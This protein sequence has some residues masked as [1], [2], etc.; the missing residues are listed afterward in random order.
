M[1]S[2]INYL[3]NFGSLLG[4]CL[5]RQIVSG[6]F[7]TMYFCSNSEYAFNSLIQIMNN[8]NSGWII[9]YRHSSRASIFFI[10]C[11]IHVGKGLIYDSFYFWKIWF[12]GLIL[13]FILIAIAF[14][15][16]VLPWGQMSFWGATVITNLI[17]VIPLVGPIVVEWLWGGFNVAR[18]TLSRFFSFHFIL[19]LLIVILVLTHLIVLH[20]KGSSNPLGMPLNL[21]KIRFK[22][23]F[24]IKDIITLIVYFFF[25]L[26]LNFRFPFIFRDPENF[27][28]A[29]PILTPIHIQPEWYFLFAYCILRAVPS[30]IGGVILLVLS[31]LI[32]I[33]LSL[34]K[35]KK[36]KTLR[37]K[38]KSEW[39][40]I[41]FFFG[42]FFILTWIGILP[43][44]APF[45]KIRQVYSFLYFSFFIFF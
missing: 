44:E 42:T 24:F 4:L 11:F 36:N 3:W 27:I 32:I 6:F 35:S 16:Y 12:T 41:Y 33:W 15:G 23:Y 43:V 28:K 14:L 40:I 38:I 9:R 19:P 39:F 1:P 17:S 13:I 10:F 8:V 22:K 29:N 20:E 26:I 37:F 2:R 25:L 7:L 34:S 30:K 45:T 18:P 31:I 21:D 5:T